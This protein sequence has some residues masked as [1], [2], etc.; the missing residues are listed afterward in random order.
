MK[1]QAY[2]KDRDQDHKSLTTKAI[3][4]DLMKECHNELTL[5]EIVSLKI[6]SRTMK[7]EVW[8]DIPTLYLG[9]VWAG[10]MEFGEVMAALTISVSADSFEGSFRDTIDI[11]VDVI[12]LVPVVLVVF[13]AATVVMTLAQ[14]GE[15]IWGIQEHLLKVAIQE[16]LRALR[17]KV[18]VVEAESASLRVMIRTMGAVETVLRNCIRDERKTRIE[19]AR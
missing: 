8:E 11:D 4:F 7:G 3:S 16:E 2:D 5:G 18:D 19:I 12:H 14:H 10:K 9:F 13:P 17:D 1:E 6:L 15:A